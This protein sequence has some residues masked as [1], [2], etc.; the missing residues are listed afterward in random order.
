M[1]LHLSDIRISQFQ[2]TSSPYWHTNCHNYTRQ[3]C[4]AMRQLRN[5]KLM[6]GG[7]ISRRSISRR[8]MVARS[9]V[10]RPNVPR[11]NGGGQVSCSEDEHSWSL[12]L[13]ANTSLCGGFTG[14]QWQRLIISA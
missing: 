13:P 12:Y 10:W 6:G 3:R 11:S 14:F 5:C 4:H 9:N 7:L 8:S 2:N 1:A